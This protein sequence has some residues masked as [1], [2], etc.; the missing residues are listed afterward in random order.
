MKPLIIANWKAHPSTPREAAELARKTELAASAHRNIE[1]VV[2]PPFPFLG[3]I[4]PL[5]K[6]A[7]LGSQ[8]A[9]WGDVG[10]Y[11][12]EVS[13]HQLKHLMVRY[14][15]VGHSERRLLLGQTSHVHGTRQLQPTFP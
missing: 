12:G 10:P 8:N 9:F 7:K 14:V 4:T 5:L 1:V 3:A 11:T 6:R 13:W 2:A 15:I